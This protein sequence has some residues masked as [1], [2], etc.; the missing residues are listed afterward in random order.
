MEFNEDVNR[1]INVLKCE[2]PKLR[3]YAAISLD[4]LGDERAFEH[5]SVAINDENTIVRAN[6][7]VALS[8][9]NNKK[10][11]EIILA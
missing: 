4:I 6:S 11:L 1:L 7:I 2:N 8:K 5:L 3:S 10:F 9:F